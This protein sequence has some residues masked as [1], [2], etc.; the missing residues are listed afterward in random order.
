MTFGEA[1]FAAPLLD[2]YQQIESPF[3]FGYETGIGG[4]V[5]LRRKF[6][7]SNCLAV[8]FE[9]FDKTLPS[10][11]IDVSFDIMAYNIDFV[12]YQNHGVA[13]VK[14]MIRMFDSMREDAKVTPIRMCNGER[15]MKEAGLASGSYFTQLVGSMSNYILLTYAALKN[16][17]RIQAIKVLGDDSLLATFQE[18]SPDM[19]QNSLDQFGV[20]VNVAKSMYY[21]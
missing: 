16:D 5:K 3:A 14:S 20:I 17:V 7:A 8:D 18:M 4:C 11:L 21:R 13:R 9:S 19:V 12:R 2:A 10:W 1:V 6:N 15:Y